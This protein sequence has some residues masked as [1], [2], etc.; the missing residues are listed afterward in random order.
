MKC[1][2][3]GQEFDM[4]NTNICGTCADELRDEENAQIAMAQAEDE[5][6]ARQEV[7]KEEHER[8][9]EEFRQGSSNY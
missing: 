8:A 1:A 7:E 2:K 3:C 9:Q 4:P 5:A 6:L